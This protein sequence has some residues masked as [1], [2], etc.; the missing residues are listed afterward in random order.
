[1]IDYQRKSSSYTCSIYDEK[2]QKKMGCVSDVASAR[3]SASAT[4]SSNSNSAIGVF[5]VGFSGVFVVIWV[6]F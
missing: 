2:V 4:S 6:H 5:Y 1:M 3:A